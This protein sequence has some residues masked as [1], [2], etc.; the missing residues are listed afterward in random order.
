VFD[1]YFTAH[2]F[3]LV[4]A[5]PAGRVTYS[6]GGSFV[7]FS[8]WLEDAPKFA[9]M[10]AIGVDSRY[11]SA[12]HMGFNRIGVWYAIPE[13]M[14]ARQYG[15]W[16]FSDLQT[17]EVSLRRIR[18]EVIE[19]YAKPLWLCPKHLATLIDRRRQEVSADR[20]G[21]ALEMKRR[22]AEAAFTSSDY[23]Q[24]LTIYRDIGIERLTPLEQK[25]VEIAIRR[26]AL[27]PGAAQSLGSEV[28]K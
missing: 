20:D 17:L 2:E 15:T 24:A 28:G 26:L 7:E 8:Y 22:D 13:T 1:A 4:H 19:V 10:I 25:R 23:E 11:S 16:H 9:P 18:S 14:E 27:W 5:D 21:Q 6:D 12:A 3:R